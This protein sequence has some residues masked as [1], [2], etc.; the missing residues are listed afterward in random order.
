VELKRRNLELGIF[1]KYLVLLDS[2]P[3]TSRVS[4]DDYL[5]TEIETQ[6]K[7]GLDKA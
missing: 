1:E 5:G 3:P 4:S 6:R 7:F 2:G